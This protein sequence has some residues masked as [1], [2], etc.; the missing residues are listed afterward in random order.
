MFI[1]PSGWAQDKTQN[2][3]SNNAGSSDTDAKAKNI[4]A[5]I[6]LMRT[7]VRQQKAE[8]MGSVM[9]LSAEDAAKF[10]RFT[11]NTTLT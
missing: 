9:E 11:A 2:V 7:N 1:A 10:W 3:E 4:R 5:Y 8:L 6:E